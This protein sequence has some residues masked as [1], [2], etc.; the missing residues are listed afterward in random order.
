MVRI[1][2]LF[3]LLINGV[4]LGVITHLLTI[5][6]NFLGH[7][8]CIDITK[9]NIPRMKVW[10]LHLLSIG[11]FLGAF[12]GGPGKTL[13]KPVNNEGSFELGSKLPLFPYNRGWSSTQ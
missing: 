9:F 6:P 8:R 4:F 11:S 13:Q 5:D 1:N 12:Y 7:P 2:G 3:H 10:K